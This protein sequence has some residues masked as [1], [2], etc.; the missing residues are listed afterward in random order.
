MRRGLAKDGELLTP[1]AKEK[2]VMTA[3]EMQQYW[4]Y[5]SNEEIVEKGVKN[6]PRI[7]SFKEVGWAD[8]FRQEVIDVASLKEEL[9]RSKTMK[10]KISLKKTQVKTG[11]KIDEEA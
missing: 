11:E 4:F 5:M 8:P 6:T 7:L 9:T 2:A 1:E 10:K 3:E